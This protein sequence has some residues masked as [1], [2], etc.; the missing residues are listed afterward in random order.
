[1]GGERLSGLEARAAGHCFPTHS[2]GKVFP[3]AVPSVH[4]SVLGC[5]S[6]LTCLICGSVLGCPSAA[7]TSCELLSLGLDV[8]LHGGHVFPGPRE[9][10]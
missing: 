6:L 8:S 4:C 7:V 9:V 5:H 10:G 2:K 3:V 1:M